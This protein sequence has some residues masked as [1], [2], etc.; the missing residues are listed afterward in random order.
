MARKPAIPPAVP[1]VDNL[2]A[3]VLP[4]ATTAAAALLSIEPTYIPGY[5]T[6]TPAFALMSVYH[7]TIYRPDLLPAPAVFLVGIVLDLLSGGPIGVTALLLLLARAIVRHYRQWFID[8]AF[9][10]VWAGFTLLAAAAMLGMWSVQS[11]LELRAV[12]IRGSIFQTVLTVSLFPIASFLLG[13][14]QRAL[15][16]AG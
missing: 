14:T 9:P 16:A 3:R 4:L 8:R 13:R 5:A 11:L 6:L 7:W 15:M 1:Q 12:E 10:F 2:P